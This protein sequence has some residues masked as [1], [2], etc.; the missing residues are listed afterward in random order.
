MIR[1]VFGLTIR[2]GHHVHDF[3]DRHAEATHESMD[4]L[5]LDS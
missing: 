4:I 1:L 3:T 2:N 5:Q